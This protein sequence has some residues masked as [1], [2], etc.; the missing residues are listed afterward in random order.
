[1]KKYLCFVLFLSLC[2]LT[3]QTVC[4][5]NDPN[6]LIVTEVRSTQID[7]DASDQSNSDPGTTE[8]ATSDDDDL[9]DDWDDEDFEE[10]AEETIADPLETINRA[11]FHFNDKLYFWVLKPVASG[12]RAVFP[13]PVRVG[14]SNFF[15]NIGFPVRFV[16][17]MFQRKPDGMGYE[18]ARFFLN[19]TI[20]VAGFIDV[21]TS[22]QG[23]PKQDEDLGQTMGAYGLG[24]GFFI[25]WP[26]IGPSSFRDTLGLVG[27]AFLDP[28]FYLDLEWS[29]ALRGYDIINETSLIIG[30]YEDLKR[31]ALDPYVA[32]RDAYYQNRKTR[33]QE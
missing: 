23:W 12:Y 26:F 1:M 10:E 28:I 9:D 3:V 6:I 19:S 8:K 18:I 22:D 30:D 11:F 13:K 7:S 14:V 16:N 4:A 20:G 29:L 5:E 2:L 27:D 32:L 21:S 15:S 31:A 17:C 25:N 24:N 33:I